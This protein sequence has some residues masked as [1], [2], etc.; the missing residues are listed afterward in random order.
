[1]LFLSILSFDA[2][3]HEAILEKR[4]LGPE[5]VPEGVKVLQ[6]LVDLSKH[7]VFGISEVSDPRA[8]LQANMA[9]NDAGE[10]ETVLVMETEEVL[11]FLDRMNHR[12]RHKRK[13]AQSVEFNP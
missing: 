8:I 12:G 13:M 2:A 7:R 4:A 9:W 11:E 1:M 3:N 5:K 10:V 6:E